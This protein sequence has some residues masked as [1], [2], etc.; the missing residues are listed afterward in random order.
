[1]PD[2]FWTGVAVGSLGWV[3]LSVAALALFV[4]LTRGG[5]DDG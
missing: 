2:A 3:A 4:G 1:M 5:G